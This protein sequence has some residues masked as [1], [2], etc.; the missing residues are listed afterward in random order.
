L[1]A[2]GSISPNSDRWSIKIK[3]EIDSTLT[4]RRSCR[5]DICGSCAMNIDGTNTLAC[6]SANEDVRG[7]VNIYPLPHTNVVKDLV[8]VMTNYTQFRSIEP[9]GYAH[10]G[11]RVATG[12]ERP[13][14]A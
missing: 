9:W 10:A 7:T 8:P 6:T 2:T 13:R 14:A 1:T 3:N 11:E 5:E 4:F 12:Q